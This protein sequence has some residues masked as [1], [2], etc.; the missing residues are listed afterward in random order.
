MK[1]GTT[2]GTPSAITDVTVNANFGWIVA[3]KKPIGEP[4]WLVLC[5]LQDK[6]AALERCDTQALENPGVDFAVFRLHAMCRGV[7]MLGRVGED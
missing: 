1:A 6:V 5:I 7:V 2:K 3:Q 4:T